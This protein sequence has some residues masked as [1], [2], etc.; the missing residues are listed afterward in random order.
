MAELTVPSEGFT[1]TSFRRDEIDGGDDRLIPA[2]FEEGSGMRRFATPED[3]ALRAGFT[4]VQDG[5]GFS[6][7]FWYKEIW[8]VISGTA[9][10]SVVDKRTGETSEETL[11][12]GDA[13][14][15]PEGVRVTLSNTSGDDFYFLYCAVPA[16]NRDAQWLAAME[17][18]D[19]NDV[20]V[21]REFP[22]A[23]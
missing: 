20:R 3:R 17:D 22:Q 6:T 7:Y 15:Y 11:E 10:L 2:L 14:Y 19:I 8:Y 23:D 21:R 18:E 4:R 5:K 1:K 9:S 13:T 16:S 12:A